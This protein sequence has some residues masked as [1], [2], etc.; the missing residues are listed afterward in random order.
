MSGYQNSIKNVNSLQDITRH[1]QKQRRFVL[2]EFS[3]EFSGPALFQWPSKLCECETA[4]TL[5]CLSRKKALEVRKTAGA[6]LKCAAL[7][8]ERQ[9]AG[10]RQ[11]VDDCSER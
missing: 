7:G 1:H 9:L 8:Q 4:A 3:Q 5:A 6:S 10:F 2:R 11:I